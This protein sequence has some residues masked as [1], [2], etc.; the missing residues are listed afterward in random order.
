NSQ[1]GVASAVD[2]LVLGHPGFHRELSVAAAG[3]AEVQKGRHV[4]GKIVIRVD[5]RIIAKLGGEIAGVAI[6]IVPGDAKERIGVN[7]IVTSRVVTGR[8]AIVAGAVIWIL[9]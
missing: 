1:D 8:H 4:A 2:K 9:I 5:G 6:D 3:R 7:S